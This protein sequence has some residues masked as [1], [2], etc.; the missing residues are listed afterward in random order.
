MVY[1]RSTF[2]CFSFNFSVI[3]CLSYLHTKKWEKG[4]LLS[5]IVKLHLLYMHASIFK[6]LYIFYRALFV[7][8][9][10]IIMTFELS[11]P[12]TDFKCVGV[13]RCNQYIRMT[14]ANKH[15]YS[16]WSAIFQLDEW[17]H[18]YQFDLIA[19]VYRV[20]I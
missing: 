13:L 2:I 1:C 10:W 12:A 16:I 19:N 4:A 8:I 17:I 5:S 9:C 3:Y 20:E 14:C 18:F 11:N 15:T 7:C 6:I